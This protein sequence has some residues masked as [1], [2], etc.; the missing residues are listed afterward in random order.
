MCWLW[1]GFWFAYLSYQGVRATP[2]QRPPCLTTLTHW[3]ILLKLHNVPMMTYP[4]YSHFNLLGEVKSLVHGHP[5]YKCESCD[6]DSSSLAPESAPLCFLQA[7]FRKSSALWLP[8]NCIKTVDIITRSR[9]GSQ[10]QLWLP[11]LHCITLWVSFPICKMR[12]LWCKFLK[13][14]FCL[15]MHTFQRH[16]SGIN[17][18]PAVWHCY[19]Q[20]NQVRNQ[21]TP[22]MKFSF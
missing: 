4:C 22:P 3:L 10:P 2:V 18:M 19:L 9:N 14:S 16:P 17:I 11:I 8:W 6:S 21:A 12:V 5:V 13:L 20:N 7:S 1:L 15:P